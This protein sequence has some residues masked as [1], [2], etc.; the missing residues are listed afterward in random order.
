GGKLD[1]FEMEFLEAHNT[2][3]KQHGAPPLQFSRDLCKSAQKWADYLLSINSLEHSKS[4]NGE[5]LFYRYNS[6]VQDISGKEA[7]DSW[8]NEIKDYDFK[9]PGF[10]G[11]TG[12]FTQ[13]VWK[14]TKEVGVGKATNGKGLF[15]IVG[16]Y[17]PAG[18]MT[19]AG[20]FERNVLPKGTAIANTPG[21]NSQDSSSSPS[22][23][24]SKS[25]HANTDG[26][27]PAQVLVKRCCGDQFEVE[28]LQVHNFYRK[29]HG[30]PPLQLNR[31]LCQASQKWADHLL[32]L[33]ALQHSDTSY[34]ENIWYKWS[35]N[36]RD[37]SGKEAVESWY[38]EIQNYDF[39]QPGFQSNTG[40]FTQVVWKDSQE[41]GIAK[42]TDGKGMVIAVAQ[43]NPAGNITNPGYYERNVLPKGT[44]VSYDTGNQDNRKPGGSTAGI[45][46]NDTGSS[47]QDTR[48]LDN[49]VS[50][51]LQANNKYR[52]VHGA[53]PLKL[54]SEISQGAQKWAEHL[55]S[56]RT[57]QH[58][59]APYGENVWAKTGSRHITATGQEVADA[60]YREIKDYNFSVP[61][62]QKN[63]GHFTQMV[64]RESKE[65][66]IGKASDGKG[67]FVVVA[68]YK[69]A[70]NI[71]NPGYYNR[72]V[73]PAGSE[74]TD[75]ESVDF[76][77]PTSGS[78]NASIPDHEYKAFAKE[79]VDEHNKYRSSHG[80]EP[81]QLSPSLSEEAQ[82][83]A[84][85][86]VDIKALQN[87]NS[88][89]GESLWYRWS[90]N[91][92]GP[93]VGKEVAD[94]WYNEIKKYDFN[95]PGF[96]KGAGN[97][98][99]MVWKDSARVGVGYAADGKGMFIVVGFYAPPGNIANSGYF[100]KNVF[101]KK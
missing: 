54:S 89:H 96:Q 20:Y 36:V 98:T 27:S 71:T 91:Q 88:K 79:L 40:H 90:T 16:Q 78:N 92:T 38:N 10:K 47:A 100:H 26:V 9:N 52:E 72:N 55:V 29:Q 42:A 62:Y 19:N 31:E 99:Q 63:T 14:D 13:V 93:T 56:L 43:Y 97:F 83:W 86:L 6:R 48:R 37:V 24:G 5:N 41:L 87:S 76:G 61:G 49:F 85:H 74:V 23:Y 77:K 67:M 94:S 50:E 22:R 69:P 4:N 70:G 81:L 58:S 3:R 17:S 2:Y 30:A 80:V 34:G 44:P 33:K 39:E 8:Y 65:V 21:S 11:N 59:D 64:W 95:S 1:Q 73:L 60:W 66:G 7:V 101:L 12:H 25:S 46:N 15:F 57:L 84:E 45:G 53:Q 75:N 18:N 68:Q 32:T 28:A 51:F 35:S 82:K